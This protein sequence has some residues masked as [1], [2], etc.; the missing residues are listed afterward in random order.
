MS[1]ERGSLS[2]IPF[3]TK[4]QIP[5]EETLVDRIN[6]H[7]FQPSAMDSPDVESIGFCDWMDLYSNPKPENLFLAE[8]WTVFGIRIDSRSVSKS[9]VKAELSREIRAAGKQL[10]KEEIDEM[11]SEIEERLLKQMPFIPELV[12]VAWNPRAGILYS[13]GYGKVA[14]WLIDHLKALGVSVEEV[15]VVNPGELNRLFDATQAGKIFDFSNEKLTYAPN[16]LPNELHTALDSSISINFEDQRVSFS[17]LGR[18]TLDKCQ[19]L[20]D[21]GAKV[22]SMKILIGPYAVDKPESFS[23]TLVSDANRIK[24]SLPWFESAE[25]KINQLNLRLE[26]LEAVRIGWMLIQKQISPE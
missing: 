19:A 1:L 2:L 16:L 9:S 10:S 12:K 5:T 25:G 23:L 3:I 7:L 26:V 13:E 24:L 8:G 20:L 4:G 15:R 18:E 17:N 22:R 6:K 14:K 11:A 21:L